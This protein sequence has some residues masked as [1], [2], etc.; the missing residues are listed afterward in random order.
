MW[1]FVF[2][3]FDPSR[4]S[5]VLVSFDSRL[6][7]KHAHCVLRTSRCDDNPDRRHHPEVVT[8]LDLA[9]PPRRDLTS[10]PDQDPLDRHPYTRA[11]M[12]NYEPLMQG[13]VALSRVG[14]G[15]E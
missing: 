5:I 6:R 1:G 14:D 15:S 3:A 7:N 12:T 11:N 2:L 9:Q 4:G 13:Y 8:L 10:H